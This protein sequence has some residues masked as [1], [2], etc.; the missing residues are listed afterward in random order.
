MIV[1]FKPHTYLNTQTDSFYCKLNFEIGGVNYF[2]ERT[3]STKKNG[4][5]T[6]VVDFWKHDAD[7]N[8]ISLNGEQR[9][10]TNAIIRDHVGSYDDFVLTTLSL[11]NNNAIFIDKSQSERKDL[12]AQFMGIDIFDQLHSTASEDIKEINALL[13]RFNREDFDETLLKLKKNLIM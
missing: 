10:G 11:Q 8:T 3:A 6:V 9:A 12:L 5:V 4:D 7:G 13:K 1:L 2:I